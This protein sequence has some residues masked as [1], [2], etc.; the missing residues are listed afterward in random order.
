MR[1][2][3]ILPQMNLVQAGRIFIKKC[4]LGFVH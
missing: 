3:R 2:G 1:R 4:Q